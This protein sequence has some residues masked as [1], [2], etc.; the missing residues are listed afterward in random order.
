MSSILEGDGRVEVVVE[1]PE[2][3]WTAFYVEIRWEGELAFPYGN[4]TEITVLPDTLPYDANGA[5]RE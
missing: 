5:K 2:S 4:C 1:T 3:G